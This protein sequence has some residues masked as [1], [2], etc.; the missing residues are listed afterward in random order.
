[1][2]A[3]VSL[4]LTV[5]LAGALSSCGATSPDP[6]SGT[7]PLAPGQSLAAHATVRFVALEGGCW[8]VETTL[9]ARYEPVNL[10]P[11]YRVDG[12]SVHVVLRDAPD[13]VSYCMV[14]PL[15]RI[16]TI[17]SSPRAP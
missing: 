13:M 2:K 6:F 17:T 7:Q 8:V 15:V 14:A 4:A 9:G 11:A 16:D 1:M 10:P 12:L 3:L 5:L